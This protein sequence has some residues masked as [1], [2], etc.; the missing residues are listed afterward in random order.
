MHTAVI[1]V[2]MGVIIGGLTISAC[3][4]WLW[5]IIGTIGFARGTCTSRVVINSLAI[6]V[7]PAVLTSALLWIRGEAFALNTSFALGL[8]VMPLLLTALGLRSASDG[9]RAGGHMVSGIRQLMDELLGK[10]HECGGCAHD[11]GPPERSEPG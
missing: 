7:A 11:H 1:D 4:G 3:W 2:I 10:H 8:M 9:R 6:A 5:L